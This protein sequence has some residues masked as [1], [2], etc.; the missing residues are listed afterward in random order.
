MRRTYI[1]AEGGGSGVSTTILHEDKIDDTQVYLVEEQGKKKVIA[2]GKY[3]T[4]YK[5]APPHIKI[6]MYIAWKKMTGEYVPFLTELEALLF[7]M[8]IIE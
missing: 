5:E 6:I 8:G 3:D 1:Y 4:R 7:A 2:K